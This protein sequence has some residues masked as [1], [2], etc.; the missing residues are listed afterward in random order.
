MWQFFKIVTTVFVLKDLY[1]SKHVRWIQ[2]GRFR[3]YNGDIAR[4]CLQKQRFSSALRL[5]IVTIFSTN[6]NENAAF[7]IIFPIRMASQNA[8]SIRISPYGTV[9]DVHAL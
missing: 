4:L 5:Q 6:F 2:I 7:F 1:G 8:I 3:G 9:V